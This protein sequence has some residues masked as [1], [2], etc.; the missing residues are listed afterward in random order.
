MYMMYVYKYW[1]SRSPCSSLYF[2]SYEYM[3]ICKDLQYSHRA[4]AVGL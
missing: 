4:V 1:A 2:I 3:I